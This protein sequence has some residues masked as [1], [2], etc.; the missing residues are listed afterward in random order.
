M[1]W[2]LIFLIFFNLFAQDKVSFL[3]ADWC[4]YTCGHF[5]TK[6]Y[7]VEKLRK[8]LS[9]HQI[10]LEVKI[11]PWSRA[12]RMAENKNVAGL[13][14]AAKSEA[15]NLIYPKKRIS[16]YQNCAFTVNQDLD[17]KKLSDISRFK[18]G[19]ISNYSYGE[20][21][22]SYIKKNKD[23][24]M[25]LSGKNPG[26]R[27]FELVKLKRINLFLEERRV[28]DYSFK[29]EVKKVFCTKKEPFYTAINPHHPLSKKLKEI[30]DSE[31]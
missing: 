2:F 28:A 4:P 24:V 29:E 27:L 23:K 18:L 14:T 6:G 22:D 25:I 17:V 8:I 26:D 30:L 20:E 5:Q 11:L 9:K 12:L 3:A 19:V 10:K 31:L 16:Y 1:K 7:V 15:P 21:F 13:V